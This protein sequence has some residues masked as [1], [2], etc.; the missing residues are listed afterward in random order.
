MD[1]KQATSASRKSARNHYLGA[2]Y[3]EAFYAPS[4][5]TYIGNADGQISTMAANTMIR[6]GMAMIHINHDSGRAWLGQTKKGCKI[7]GESSSARTFHT[8]GSNTLISEYPRY[9]RVNI[10]VL[11]IMRA[12]NKAHPTGILRRL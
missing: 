9:K 12:V 4:T 6:N 11:D 7:Y 5:G 2:L 10:D 1:A 8:D 3:H